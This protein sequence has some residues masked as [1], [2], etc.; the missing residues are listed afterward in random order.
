MSHVSKVIFV[1]VAVLVLR[2]E[3]QAQAK[4]PTSLCLYQPSGMGLAAAEQ[5]HLRVFLTERLTALGLVLLGASDK[6]CLPGAP[7]PGQETSNKPLLGLYPSFLK[8]ASMLQFKLEL[9]DIQAQEKRWSQDWQ[10][11]LGTGAL[12]QTWLEA[13]VGVLIPIDVQK[14]LGVADDVDATM[15]KVAE[16]SQSPA[17]EVAPAAETTA[18]AA[19]LVEVSLYSTPPGA[20]V[21]L[22]NKKQGV[23]N[24]LARLKPGRYKLTLHKKKY[25]DF[26]LSLV[27]QPKRAQNIQLKLVPRLNT[28]Q[29]TF[30]I[31]RWSLLGTTAL[32]GILWG[33]FA[34]QA[35]NKY[36]EVRAQFYESSTQGLSGDGESLGRNARISAI[37]T[38]ISAVS[39][40]VF[41]LALEL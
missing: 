5:A 19:G 18:D 22:N 21:Y 24:L 4:V 2:S 25:E 37:S 9:R 32:S 14:L 27:V 40:A 15:F 7:A 41:W 31:V 8:M 20:D 28:K 29:H 34:A 1:F 35:N 36:D 23:T 11:D 10:F 12:D 26:S 13:N 30:K 17:K 6:P 39:T 3:V 16:P 38:G 33:V